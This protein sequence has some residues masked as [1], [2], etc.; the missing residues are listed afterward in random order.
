MPQQ[1]A[2]TVSLR[3][4]FVQL[5]RQVTG[6]DGAASTGARLA[7]VEPSAV[8]RSPCATTETDVSDV[9]SC[10]QRVGSR[11]ARPLLPPP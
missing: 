4:A 1:E 3:A 11:D 8:S 9:F 6:R 7:S 5:A 2:T 10:R